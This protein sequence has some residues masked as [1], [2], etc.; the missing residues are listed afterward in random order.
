MSLLEP[1]K[2]YMVMDLKATSHEKYGEG[3]LSFLQ[4]RNNSSWR[5]QFPPKYL[6]AFSAEDIQD[7][8]AE[9]T[10][11]NYPF[12]I[13]REVLM[14]KSFKIDLAPHCKS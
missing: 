9:I 10:K 13:F 1:N 7:L 8:R 4:G 6:A 11:K 5:S 2:A 12:L 14:D 3:L